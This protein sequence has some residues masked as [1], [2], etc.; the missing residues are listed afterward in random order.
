MK[1]RVRLF[2][3]LGQTFPDY[4]PTEGLDVEIPKGT[5]VGELLAILNL[6]EAR[7]AAVALEGR[8]LKA[9]DIIPYGVPVHILQVM[10][11]G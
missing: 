7:G 10:S 5:T 4:E 1:V 11:G 3:T 2:G 9:E 8:I 6:S